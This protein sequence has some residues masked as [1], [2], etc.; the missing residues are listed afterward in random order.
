MRESNTCLTH[1]L[2]HSSDECKVLGNF[3]AKY[4]KSQPTKDR[5]IKPV[6]IKI[7]NKQQ[8]NRI[9][10]NNAVDEILFNE[11]K[12]VSAVNH[13]APDFLEMDYDEN[14]LYQMENMSLDET[15]EKIDWRKRVFK[16]ECSYV[17]ENRNE[18]IY[19]HDKKLKNIS[20]C[21]FLHNIINPPKRAKI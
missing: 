15:K 4:A 8:E 2:G 3:G 21:I 13:E 11:T 9:I 17:I 12:K 14:D 16:Y 7:L 20:E 5:R 1:G 6:P 10:I 18:M 19:I